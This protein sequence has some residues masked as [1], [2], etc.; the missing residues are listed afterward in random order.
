MTRRFRSLF[1]GLLL[2]AVGGWLL[3]QNLKV[4][5]PDIRSLWPAFPIIG[6]M[7]LLGDYFASGRQDSGKVFVG[8]AA[9][10]VGAFF[11]MF[12]LGYWSWGSMEQSWPLFVLIGSVAFFAQWLAEP[13]RR[14][15]LLPAVIALAVGLSFLPA[16]SGLLPDT[17]A[18]QILQLWP[19]AL[20]I[21]G[22]VLLAQ[23]VI[24]RG[25]S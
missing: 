16:T 6:G 3:A 9:I 18:R 1:P 19:L 20:V 13:S 15:V 2:L 12:T 5:L 7:A 17:L 4:P 24:R 25:D 11:F 22:V 21:A 14:S 8:V 10:L 23:S